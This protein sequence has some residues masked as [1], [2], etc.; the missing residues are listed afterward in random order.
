MYSLKM[1]EFPGDRGILLDLWYNNLAKP[2]NERFE[3]MYG[4]NEHV[5]I[6]T[7]LLHYNG[8][9]VVGC[10]S[11][12]KH[13]FIIREQSVVVGINIDMIVVKRHRTLG[14]ASILL[15]TLLTTDSIA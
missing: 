1:F 11:L 7:W 14:P 3:S 10:A 2:S 8:E 5:P 13:N 9:T 6:H 15:K 4:K 12:A